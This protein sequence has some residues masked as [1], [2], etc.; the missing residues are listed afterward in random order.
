MAPHSRLFQSRFCSPAFSHLVSIEKEGDT[1]VAIGRDTI[2]TIFGGSGFIGRYVVEKLAHAGCLIRV[3][4][5]RPE[6]ALFLKTSGEIG[7][8]TPLAINIR[9]QQSVDAVVAGAHIVINLVGILQQSGA[10]RFVAVQAEGAGRVARAA[11]AAGVAQL[12]HVSAIGADPSSASVYASSKAA[13]EAAVRAAFPTAT[14]LRPSI[15]F[16]A[17]DEFLNRFARM[18][19]VSPVLPLV[20][21]KTKFQ[22]V[23][24]GD[25]AQAV[26]AVLTRP[27]AA[28]QIYELGGPRSYAFRTLIKMMLTWIGRHRCVIDL[29]FPLASLQASLMQILPRP[30]LTVDQVRLLRR[31]NIVDPSA[32]GLADLDI[33]PTSLESVA[34][35][36]LDRYRPHAKVR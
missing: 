1:M 34:P 14:I 31:D 21:G 10:Q 19:M 24:V 25:V 22:P 20:G 29:P 7:Q 16:G 30:P 27:E 11:K 8:I 35:D 2:V 28:G 36:Y 5:R 17:E 9:D 4:V 26:M 6:R 32:K 13:G 12:V 3:A 23:Y 18:A 33:A 15:V